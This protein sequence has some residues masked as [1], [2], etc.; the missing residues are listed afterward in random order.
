MVGNKIVR[1]SDFSVESTTKLTSDDKDYGLQSELTKMGVDSDGMP[2]SLVWYG[3]TAFSDKDESNKETDCTRDYCYF[4]YWSKGG[5][6]PLEKYGT[7]YPSNV[8]DENSLLWI[9]VQNYRSYFL[10]TLNKNVSDMRLITFEELTNL[11]CTEGANSTCTY[12]F[13]NKNLG[14]WSTSA[15]SKSGIWCIYIQGNLSYSGFMYGDVL[16]VRPVITINKSEI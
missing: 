9:P 11:G 8:Y 14:Y 10:N 13:V 1:K 12:D 2:E 16:G 15:Y 5:D 6:I 4:G 7:S 3:I